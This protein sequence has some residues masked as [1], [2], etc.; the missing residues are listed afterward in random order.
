MAF[1]KL[2]SQMEDH[3][4]DL[5]SETLHKSG[6]SSISNPHH[7]II[8]LIEKQ[9]DLSELSS[10]TLTKA[11]Q[12]GQDPDMALLC[13]RSTAINSKLPSPAELIKSRRYRTLLLHEQCLNQGRRREKS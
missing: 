11:Q 5:Y 12:S 9:R 6:D 7:T 3:N 2:L 10:N 8:S 13:Y 4:S 1:H